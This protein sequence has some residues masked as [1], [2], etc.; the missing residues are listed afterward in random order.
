MSSNNSANIRKLER[1]ETN[2]TTNNRT[3]ILLVSLIL[4]SVICVIF[5]WSRYLHCD[6]NSPRIV[7]FDCIF[8]RRQ[9]AP[10]LEIPGVRQLTDDVYY[11]KSPVWSPDG[12]TIAVM[13]N[14]ENLPPSGPDPNAWEI[15]LIDSATGK[16]NELIDP[17]DKDRAKLYPSWSA[18]TGQL[19]YITQVPSPTDDLPWLTKNVLS[20]YSPEDATIQQFECSTCE[21]PA[22][23]S[24]STVL[25]NVNLGKKDNERPDFGLALFDTTTEQ[26]TELMKTDLIGPFAVSPDATEILLVDDQCS[27][28]WNYTIGAKSITSFIDSSELHK[29]DPNWSWNGQKIIYI[30]KDPPLGAPTYLM[31]SNADGSNPLRILE[32]ELALYQIRYP[33]WSPDGT[34]IVFTYGSEGASTVYIMDLPEHLRP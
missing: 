1:D 9:K 15:V 17:N 18:E 19:L 30:E 24:K 4:I 2:G 32:P 11:Y 26:L 7:Q 12:N 6:P 20:L 25:V 10:Q 16:I 14:T 23:L 8:S 34:R 33:A 13:R 28:I 27:G 3:Q 29:C 5:L 22:W 31:I 21:W